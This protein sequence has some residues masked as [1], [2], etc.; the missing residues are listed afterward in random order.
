MLVAAFEMAKA[1]NEGC[2]FAGARERNRRALSWSCGATAVQMLSFG[3]RSG[4]GPHNRTY[5]SSLVIFAEKSNLTTIVSPWSGLMD[6]ILRPISKGD[7]APV[8]AICYAAFKAIA[9]HHSFAPDFPNPESAVGLI[10]YM[11]S[12]ADIY[13]AV[14][15]V[16]GRIVGSAF[17]WESDRVAG[18][19]PITVDPAAQN[20]GVGRKLM[21]A[22]LERAQQRKIEGIRLVQAAYHARSL[23]LYTKLGFIVRE[24]LTVMQGPAINESIEGH[25]VCGATAADLQAAN[26]LCERVHGHC[27]QGELRA[28]LQ[29]GTAI[30]V[31]RNGRLT[32]YATS[33]GF[34]GHA[35]GETTSDLEALIGASSSFA[36]PGFI[37]PLRNT[38]LM[39]WCLD[40]DLHIMQPMTLMTIGPYQEPAGAFL[41]SILY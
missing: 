37:V 4:R 12:R 23:S 41:P 20:N 38:E 30:V 25:T 16:E 18:V 22:V 27:R 39:Q 11:L 13:G 14:A 40:H 8:G 33:I 7:A 24:P 19:A 6:P 10:D 32:G 3:L 21:E 15:E 5:I 29:Q 36:G 17:L 26:A 35:I 28:A 2:G 1:E 9:E 34:F 31:T